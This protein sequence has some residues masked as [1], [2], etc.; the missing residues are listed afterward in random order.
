MSEGT[1]VTA[2]SSAQPT[3][4]SPGHMT[5]WSMGL[6]QLLA[7]PNGAAAFAQFL[8]KEFAH[9]NIR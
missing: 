4:G 8:A 9:E 5:R 3:G 1:N 7:D 6:E 2:A